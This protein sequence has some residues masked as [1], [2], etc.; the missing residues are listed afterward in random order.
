MRILLIEDEKGIA[1]AICKML[2]KENFSVDAVYTGPEGL[3]YA[4]EG[5]YDAI[6]LD[7][8]LPG[9]DGFQVLSGLRDKAWKST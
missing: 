7:V 8:M 5:I 1:D 6:I 4:L 9:M 3:D 2:K